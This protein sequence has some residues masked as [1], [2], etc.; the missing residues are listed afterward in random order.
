MRQ[1]TEEI[2]LKDLDF[3]A[4]GIKQNTKAAE[5]GLTNDYGLKVGASL[6]EIRIGWFIKN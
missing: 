2:D 3:I 5:E 1:I 6:K 4:Y